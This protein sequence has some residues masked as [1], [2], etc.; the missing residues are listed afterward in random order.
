MSFT[1]I[2]LSYIHINKKIEIIALTSNEA[3]LGGFKKVIIYCFGEPFAYWVQNPI[4]ML[5]LDFTV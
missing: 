3:T 5:S 4:R 1:D 2:Q